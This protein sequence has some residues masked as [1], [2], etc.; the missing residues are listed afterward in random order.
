MGGKRFVRAKAQFVADLQ[1]L[2]PE[3]TLKEFG[4]VLV[5]GGPKGR[6]GE[7]GIE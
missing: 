6:R 7:E 2:K 3:P 4:V 5:R 1:D